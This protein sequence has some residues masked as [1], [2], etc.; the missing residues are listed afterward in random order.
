MALPPMISA[1]ALGAM[2]QFV[3]EVAGERGLAKALC[4][5]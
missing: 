1:K 5:I 4:R 2:P 3:L